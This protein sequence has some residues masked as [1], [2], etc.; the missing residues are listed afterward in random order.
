MTHKGIECIHFVSNYI[1]G[2]S[3]NKLFIASIDVSE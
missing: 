2:L 1:E 3:I